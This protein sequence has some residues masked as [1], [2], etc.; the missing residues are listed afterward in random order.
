MLA[1][2]YIFRTFSTYIT[3]ADS[4]SV[5]S[6]FHQGRK[7]LTLHGT[8]RKISRQQTC[9][10]VVC[11]GETSFLML[12]NDSLFVPSGGI[13]FNRPHLKIYP[14]SEKGFSINI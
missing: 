8:I 4:N 1:A 3:N 9:D 12:I 11:A 5:F 14:Q 10:F 2:L 6:D 13:T 7:C